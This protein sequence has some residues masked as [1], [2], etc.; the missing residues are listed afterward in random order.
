MVTN[1]FC[2]RHHFENVKKRPCPFND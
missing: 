2:R 1:V